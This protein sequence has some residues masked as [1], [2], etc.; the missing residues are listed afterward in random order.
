MPAS[1]SSAISFFEVPSNLLLE[2]IGAKKT[3]ARITILWGITSIGMAWVK[4]ESAFYVLRF[5]L[6]AFEAIR[7]VKRS[8]PRRL[9]P[10]RRAVS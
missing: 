7:S 3:L 5:L 4:S 10:R 9:L 6:G 2:K 8:K 1:S